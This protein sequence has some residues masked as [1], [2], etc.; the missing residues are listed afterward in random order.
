MAALA[1]L[2][3]LEQP[4]STRRLLLASDCED[5]SEELARILRNAGSVESISIWPPW[6]ST[7]RLTMAKPMPLP[8]T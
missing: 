2:P 6:R 8:S 5:Q 4:Q 7:M 1:K 3:A